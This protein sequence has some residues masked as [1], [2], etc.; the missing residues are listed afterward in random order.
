[1]LM[2]PTCRPA[3][4]SISALTPCM[5]GVMADARTLHF[6]KETR[7]YLNANSMQLNL[8]FKILLPY[9]KVM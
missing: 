3:S 1:M 6:S 7:S 9:K 2:R 5:I 8:H 4:I